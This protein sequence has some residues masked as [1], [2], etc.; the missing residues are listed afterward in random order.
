MLYVSEIELKSLIIRIKNA[1]IT[2]MRKCYVTNADDSEKNILA[3]TFI[4]NR[5]RLYNKLSNLS[6]D[7]P[8][9]NSKLKRIRNRLKNQIL[10]KSTL[11]PIDSASYELFGRDV[12]LI[13]ERIITK[14]Q[15]RGY[16]YH[17]EFK[18]DACYKVLK[19]IDNFDYTKVSAITKQPVSAFSYIST[20]I[21]NSFINI[22]NKETETNEFIQKQVLM[23]KAKLGMLDDFV[24]ERNPIKP[25]LSLKSTIYIDD[26]SN[27]VDTCNEY[28]ARYEDNLKDPKFTIEI[29]CNK[30]IDDEEYLFAELIMHRHNN[31]KILQNQP[32]QFKAFEL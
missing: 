24:N 27:L 11:I 21:H 22:I 2:N 10:N 16:S 31:V 8:E 12:M 14:S 6:F 4:D 15:F 23:Q 13:V 18:S 7:N 3:N 26:K 29:V 20:I 17:D 32:N 25:D 19:Y 1:R 28:L 9:Q 5:V 30:P